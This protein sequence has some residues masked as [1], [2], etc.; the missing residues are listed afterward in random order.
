M[1]KICFGFWAFCIN[2]SS[3]EIQ[4]ITF[5]CFPHRSSHVNLI[6][7]ASLSQQTP[8]GDEHQSPW[9]FDPCQ[10]DVN[11]ANDEP[12]RIL[13]GRVKILWFHGSNQPNF[14]LSVTVVSKNDACKDK[15]KHACLKF[16][17]VFFFVWWISEKT[18]CCLGIM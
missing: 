12:T 6:H 14:K 10:M 2:L 4:Q 16:G 1:G 8:L 17:W 18:N 13:Q 3:C 15:S 7:F 9:R 11:E 5:R